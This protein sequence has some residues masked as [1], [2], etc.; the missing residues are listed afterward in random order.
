VFTLYAYVHFLF[1]FL[2]FHKSLIAV[3]SFPSQPDINQFSYS[4]IESF[5]A[6]INDPSYVIPLWAY[7]PLGYLKG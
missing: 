4:L 3:C 6:L 2:V 5:L 1:L 7:D